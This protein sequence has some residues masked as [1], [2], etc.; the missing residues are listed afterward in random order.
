MARELFKIELQ[1]CDLS[2]TMTYETTGQD[3]GDAVPC[4]VYI[5]IYI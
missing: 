4:Q 1:D 3:M 2:P 5:Y